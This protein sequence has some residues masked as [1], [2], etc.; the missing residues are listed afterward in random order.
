MK[1]FFS[2]FI[3]DT[4]VLFKSRFLAGCILILIVFILIVVAFISCILSRNNQTKREKILTLKPVINEA[5]EK[6]NKPEVQ[7]SS[8]LPAAR[9]INTRSILTKESSTATDDDIVY[10]KKSNDYFMSRKIDAGHITLKMNKNETDTNHLI[11]SQGYLEFYQPDAKSGLIRPL[12]IRTDTP[13]RYTKSVSYHDRFR[14][15]RSLDHI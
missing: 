10:K 9:I 4:I 3:L 5:M 12:T 6:I 2:F 15:P 8:L 13:K 11:L 7:Q 1:R 14:S